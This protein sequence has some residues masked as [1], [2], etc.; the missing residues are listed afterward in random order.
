MARLWIAYREGLRTL[1]ALVGEVP[2]EPSVAKLDLAPWRL[3]S[4]GPPEKVSLER[5]EAAPGRKRVL[6]EVT[7][8]DRYELCGL[9]V[10]V[11][12]SPYGPAECLRRLN[13]AAAPAG[14]SPS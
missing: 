7:P 5:V 3:F 12:E 13:I 9:G 11:F 1:G 4:A 2:L 14:G 10:G 8:S 6:L